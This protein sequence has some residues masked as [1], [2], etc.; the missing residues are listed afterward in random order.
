MRNSYRG[1]ALTLVVAAAACARQPQRAAF[2]QKVA[3][4]LKAASVGAEVAVVGPL[5]IAITP[6]AGKKTALDLASLWKA[7]AE[8]VECGD[9]VE[10]YVRS[11]VPRSLVVE[12]PAKREYLRPVLKTRQNLPPEGQGVFRPFVGELAVTYVFDS[13]DGKRPVAPGDLKA[14]GLD[15]AQV[16]AAAMANFEAVAK[17]IPHEPSSPASRVL[18]VRTGDEYA[19]SRLLL[20]QLW[21]PLK[22]EVEGDLIV[23]APTQDLVAF[24]GSGA[25]K[26][27]RAELKAFVADHLDSSRPLSP[28]MLK[29]TPAGWVP[30]A[31]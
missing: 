15:E 24:T 3:E 28:A 22:S 14:L 27:T 20:L 6:K 17:E 7:C 9:P 1:L 8:K 18:V 16:H 23:V 19:A 25:D 5:Q 11:V 2:T 13:G 21:A 26:A 12:V 4:R 10:Q 29:W 31:G 30:F